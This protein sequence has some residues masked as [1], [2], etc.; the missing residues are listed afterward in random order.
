MMPVSPPRH[1]ARLAQERRLAAQR[2][3]NERR[4]TGH[5]FYKSMEWRR[6]RDWFIKRH[7]LCVM[8]K[9][10]GRATPAVIVD[11]IR[12]I[13]QGGAALDENNLQSLCRAC[14]N[15]KTAGEGG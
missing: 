2:D 13:K 3:Y 7:P 5:Q 10:D 6:L 1:G 4:R 12:P 11:H 9:K 15:T 8:C 14:H